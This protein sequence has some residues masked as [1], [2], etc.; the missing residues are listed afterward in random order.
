MPVIVLLRHGETEW[1]RIG[2]HTS[3]TDL[4]LTARG[5]EQA[6]AAAPGLTAFDF[7]LVLSSPRRRAARTAELAG[8]QAEVEPRLA[9]WDYG[10]YEGRRTVDIVAE[11]GSW[12]L[13]EDGVPGGETAEQV[14]DRLDAVLERA[15]PVLDGGKDVCLVAHGHSL[16]V[17]A[18]RWL[19][20]R[21]QDGKYFRL[22]TA[23]L[24]Q[25]GREHG[26]PVLQAWN[27]PSTMPEALP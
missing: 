26:R 6:R 8:L 9:E 11:R 18:A 21:P 1:S 12:S 7:G 25:L 16:R 5:E 17:V 27:V 10:D 3:T 22:D 2:R 19:G 23:T 4:A 13:W 15:R 20:L 14:G 24:S